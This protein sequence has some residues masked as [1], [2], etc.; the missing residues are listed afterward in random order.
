MNELCNILIVD[1]EILVRQGIKHH[2]SWEQYGFRIVGEASNGK[3]ALELIEALRPHIIITDIVMPIMDGE[4]LTRI[5]RQNYPDIEVIVL[6]SYGEFNYVRSTF[7]QGVA[8]Y[9]LKPKLDTDELLQVLQRT[10]RKIP[11]IQYQEDAGNNRITIDHV[12]EKLISGYSIDYDAELLK[13]AFPYPR[14]ALIGI[15]Q[16]VQQDKGRSTTTS[17]SDLFSKLTDRLASACEHM[18]LRQ[19][20]S[21]VY[22]AVFLANLEP[23][24]LDAWMVAVREVAQETKQVE[25]QTGWAVS[26]LFDDFNQISSV[27]QDELPKLLS[28]RFYFPET[29]LLIEDE[30][31]QPVQVNRSFNL[32][33]FTEE[34]KRE[35]FDTAFQDLRSYVAA[36]SG[37]YTSTAFEFKSLLGNI[38]FNITI[39][40]GNQGYDMKELDAAKYSYFKTINDAPHVHEAVR[41]LETFLEEANRQILA[42]T[43]QGSSASMKKLLEYIEEHHAETLNLTTLGQYFHFNPSYLSSYFT[44]HHTEGFSEYLN[45]IRVEKA[46]ELLRSGTLPISDISSTV[47]Y[48]DPSYFTKVFKKVKGYSPSQY[49]REHLH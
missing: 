7:Q 10:A 31:P 49:R 24:E 18:V 32:K 22:T 3:E 46:A 2:L 37:N 9:I 6:S 25:P 36:M 19:L 34:M 33:Q 30:L 20:P 23:R 45:K 1:D 40:L 17:A 21:D 8:D 41:L 14:F 16:S 5:V 42:K 12:I 38:V 4:E 27:Y 15:E 13:Q 39:L 48:S 28:Y 44:A 29:A 43:Q 47:G 11:S 26:H 35:H